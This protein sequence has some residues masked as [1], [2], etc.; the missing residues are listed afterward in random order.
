MTDTFKIEN[1]PY[2]EVGE[3]EILGHLLGALIVGDDPYS[4]KIH[5]Y[6][7]KKGVKTIFVLEDSEQ[8]Y[9]IIDQITN[10]LKDQLLNQS[11]HGTLDV[12]L[13]VENKDGH[14]NIDFP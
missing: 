1:F 10:R 3:Y 5:F 13:I 6:F 7:E 2:P 11:R 8:N 12:K 4:A 9:Y 14:L